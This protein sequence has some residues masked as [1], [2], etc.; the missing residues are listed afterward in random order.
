MAMVAAGLTGDITATPAKLAAYGTENGYL[1]EENNT[2]WKFMNEAGKNWGLSCYESDM[3]EAQVM[4]ELKAG[5]PII[6]SVGP[7][8]FTQNGH[9][10]VLAG[11]EGGKIKVNDP[12]SRAT[13]SQLWDFERIKQQTKAMW[14]YSI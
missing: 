2:Y 1:D 9:F 14:V 13:S 11:C 12:F 3:T 4:T 7:G 5:H 6:C 10:I 8:D